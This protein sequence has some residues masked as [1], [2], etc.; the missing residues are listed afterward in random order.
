MGVVE[1]GV[2]VGVESFA[3]LFDLFEYDMS[4]IAAGARTFTKTHYEKC[5]ETMCDVNT[6]TVFEGWPATMEEDGDGATYAISYSRFI[7]AMNSYHCIICARIIYHL[8][9]NSP[10]HGSF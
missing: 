10:S 3:E 1:T 4:G 8:L 9:C 5:S 6:S 2:G 7:S